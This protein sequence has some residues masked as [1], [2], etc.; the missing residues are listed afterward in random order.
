[1]RLLE[2]QAME[3]FGDYGI[4]TPKNAV[5]DGS[6]SVGAL[7]GK[8][9]LNFPVVLKAQ[10]P[11]G[12][13][14]KAGGVRF[15]FDVR[16]AERI[17]GELLFSDLKGFTVKKLL[18]AEKAALEKEWYLAV[19]LDRIA[20]MPRILFSAEG[21]V[22][23]EETAK[24]RPEAIVS[25]TVNPFTGITAYA[26][27]YICS[28]S[29]VGLEYSAALKK[30]LTRLFSLFMENSCLLA[31]INPVAI[32]ADG[33]L[34]A[35]D[36]K[37]ETDDSALYRLPKIAAFKDG[38]D[39]NKLAV[40]AEKHNFLY[41]P[42]DEAGSLAVI[43]NGSGMLMSMIDLLSKNGIKTAC[44][45]D[46]GGGATKERICEAVRIVFETP[47][48]DLLFVSVFGGITRCDEVA[49][50]IGMAMEKLADKLIIIRMEGTNKDE[51]LKITSRIPNAVR[52]EDIIE[53]ICIITGMKDG[54]QG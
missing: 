33:T 14:G 19:M 48:V 47:G 27:D 36:G 28:K 1:M 40:E 5:L 17:A 45:L 31:E 23:I 15:A 39:G 10:V 4:D 7:I 34:T 52:A 26:S 54:G 50:G 8:S 22:E 46:L 41:I 13:R 42:L 30:I 24:D 25:L 6:E 21:G 32:N 38:A 44:A 16:E 51:G 20:G 35:I 37:V 53:G 3:L 2:Y 29:G 49:G 11:V 12:G 43:S 9:G 18:A